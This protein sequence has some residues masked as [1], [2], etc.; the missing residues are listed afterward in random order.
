MKI[1]VCLKQVVSP[2]APLR[3]A[4]GAAWI[5]DD[6]LPRETNEP[7]LHALELALVL[8]DR[9]Q[10]D[11]TAISLGPDS[12]VTTLR[13][14]LAKGADSAIHVLDT[15]PFPREPLQ[16]AQ[17]LAN[18]IGKGG[19]DLVL[20]GQQSVDLGNSQVGILVAGLLD[21]PHVNM[22]VEAETAAGTMRARRELEGGADQWWDIGLPCV[23]NV[24]SGTARPRFAGVRGIMAA[25]KKPLE[26]L[27]FT[28]AC[29]EPA[30]PG[31]E[32]GALACPGVRENMIRLTGS[33]TEIAGQLADRLETAARR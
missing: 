30:A 21:L 18:I 11:V 24:Q 28:A 20:T 33:A 9:H 7:D 4:D 27:S 26:T 31:M 12:C 10:A 22:V 6:G 13:D 14:A 15:D 3:I 32:Y 29:P 2:D 16:L 17:A 25:R 1:A 5:R 8:K 19:Y 23:L